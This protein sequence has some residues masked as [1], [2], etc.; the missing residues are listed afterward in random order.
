MILL[1]AQYPLT[2]HYQNTRPDH[3]SVRKTFDTSRPRPPI[4]VLESLPHITQLTP[5]Y[6]VRSGPAPDHLSVRKTFDTSDPWRVRKTFD[7]SCPRPPI[8]VLESLHHITQL[9]PSA[10][11]PHV[12]KTFDTSGPWRVGK[13]FDTSLTF[14][15]SG[16]WRVGKTFDTS[17]PRPPIAILKSLPHITQLTPHSQFWRA[18]PTSHK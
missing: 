11:P 16:P 5:H 13:T 6:I 17:R 14:D 4:A 7:T 1:A 15:T 2:P 18:S 10:R 8:A 12:R 9:T 3:L